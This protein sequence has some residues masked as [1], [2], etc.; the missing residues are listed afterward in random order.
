MMGKEYEL[1]R[2][3]EMNKLYKSDL[4]QWLKQPPTG[5]ARYDPA[6]DRLKITQ[7]N[8]TGPPSYKARGRESSV[9][10]QSEP[11]NYPPSISNRHSFGTTLRFPTRG[12]ALIHRIRKYFLCRGY[13]HTGSESVALSNQGHLQRRQNA[14]G[15]ESVHVAHVRKADD[16][17]L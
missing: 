3:H 11:G 12:Q 13:S 10:L 16:F 4:P 7:T 15:I 9:G 1:R 5:L 8:Y 2:R 17:S 14:E 6:S